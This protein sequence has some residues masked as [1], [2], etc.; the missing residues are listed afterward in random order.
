[1]QRLSVIIPQFNR[2]DALGVTLAALGRQTLPVDAF[3]VIVVDDGSRPEQAPAFAPDTFRYSLRLFRQENGGRGSA[4]NA[5]AGHASSDLFVFLDADVVPAASLLETYLGSHQAKRD[6]VLVGRILPWEP[7][8]LTLFDR[9]TRV[10]MSYDLG[11]EPIELVF[12]NLLSGNFA[13]ARDGFERLG[14]FDE[15]LRRTQDTEFGYRAVRAGLSL[16][17][18]PD[19]VAYHNHLRSPDKR[20][21]DIRESAAWTA[22]L[23]RKHP[24]LI[25][26]LPIYQDIL[27]IAMGQDSLPLVV[28]KL[29]RRALALPLS[30]KTMLLLIHVL[31]DRWP[32]PRLLKS[33]YHKTMSGYR[34]EG[35]R[36]GWRESAT[37][38]ERRTSA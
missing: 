31:E 3:E 23:M 27:P 10:E 25:G 20:C 28:R 6:S 9:I 19:A 22:R 26:A 11:P 13:I 18:C 2:L 8:S 35:F 21:A 4:R 32:N 1:M 12:Y 36:E 37:H 24:G 38:E 14:G 16:Q 30:R 15:T 17:Y 34:V 7:A 5:G 29:G 33:L